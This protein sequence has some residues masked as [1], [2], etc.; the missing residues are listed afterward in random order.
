MA[1][2][3]VWKP[4]ACFDVPEGYVFRFHKFGIGWSEGAS[5]ILHFRVQVDGDPIGPQYADFTHQ[6]GA[7]NI[8]DMLPCDFNVLGPAKVCI[9]AANPGP[10]DHTA[11][12]RIF[13]YLGPDAYGETYA[14]R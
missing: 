12:G 14:A 3:L 2:P 13:G 11:F 10:G 4:V 9:M 8:L 7:L 1:P 5:G 6:A